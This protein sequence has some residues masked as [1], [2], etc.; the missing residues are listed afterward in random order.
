MQMRRVRV[1]IGSCVVRLSLVLLSPCPSP[2]AMLEGLQL[3]SASF[4]PF[5][6][7]IAILH[8]IPISK[9]IVHTGVSHLFSLYYLFLD[10]LF[11]KLMAPRAIKIQTYLAYKELAIHI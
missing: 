6:L 10:L 1:V 5:M 2:P 4:T 3:S 11:D 7:S 8:E 9:L